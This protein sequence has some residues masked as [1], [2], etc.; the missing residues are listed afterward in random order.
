MNRQTFRVRATSLVVHDP[1]IAHPFFYRTGKSMFSLYGPLS[2]VLGTGISCELPSCLP[3][4]EIATRWA[5]III[6]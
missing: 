3:N 1:S 2:L 5:I 6:S 4:P